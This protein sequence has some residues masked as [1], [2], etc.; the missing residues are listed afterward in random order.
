LAEIR[1]ATQLVTGIATLDAEFEATS[2]TRNPTPLS[3]LK[4]ILFVL[5][6]L[7]TGDFTVV[8]ATRMKKKRWRL[9][10]F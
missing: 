6:C 2:L 7:F 9:H 4:S 5:Y 8:Q 10:V 1:I 3:V